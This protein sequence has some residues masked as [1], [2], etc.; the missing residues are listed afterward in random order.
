[1]TIA[2]QHN[3]GSFLRP[4]NIL[5]S[6]AVTTISSDGAPNATEVL[7]FIIDRRSLDRH[8]LSAKILVPIQ[9][10]ATGG[11]VNSATVTTRVLTGT[12]TSSIATALGSTGV[13]TTFGTT[14]TSTSYVGVHEQNVDLRMAQ[15][16]IRVGVT[17]TLAAS[18]SGVVRYGAVIVFGGADELPSVTEPA[19]ATTS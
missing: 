17:P 12:S 14:T 4:E 11:A 15:R 18:S 1:M 16:Y 3:I 9:V 13:T 8:Y 6:T 7:G 2:Q 5:P 19:R 10:S